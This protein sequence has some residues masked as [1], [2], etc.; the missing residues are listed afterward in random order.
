MLDKYNKEF[1]KMYEEVR[2][3]GNVVEVI[4]K[5]INLFEED[6]GIL[7]TLCHFDEYIKQKNLDKILNTSQ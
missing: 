6:V 4:K 5:Y 1:S 2:Q 3:G 7:R